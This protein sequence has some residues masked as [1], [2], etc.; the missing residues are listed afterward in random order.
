MGIL[1]RHGLSS[2]CR[3]LKRKAATASHS[4]WVY[5][6]PTTCL[7]RDPQQRPPHPGCVRLSSIR[8]RVA[9]RRCQRSSPQYIVRSY[10]ALG[11]ARPS[12]PTSRTALY[13]RR[14]SFLQC[15]KPPC[16]PSFPITMRWAPLPLPSPLPTRPTSPA[17]PGKD[18]QGRTTAAVAPEERT[19]SST[20]PSWYCGTAAGH[21][22]QRR[23]S[24]LSCKCVGGR[25]LLG[26]C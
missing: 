21:A 2:C 20:A 13:L 7:T 9:L 5:C 18:G 25:G 6:G 22:A 12:D 15:A 26:T 24:C 17:S 14:A 23:L 11:T 10:L 1:L 3:A 8:S 19:L 4:T 16:E